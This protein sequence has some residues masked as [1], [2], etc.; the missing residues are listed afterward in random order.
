MTDPA[1]QG[2][3]AATHKL[4]I[5][6][7]EPKIG[8]TLSDYFALHGHEVRVVASGEEALAL[9]DAYQPDV[10]LLDIL[11]PGLDGITTLKH[12]KRTWPPVRVII[13]SAVDHEEVIRGALRL[14][15]D[16]YVTKPVRLAELERYV[17]GYA[18]ARR[19]PG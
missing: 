15:A 12:I 17:N 16:F 13:M 1:P 6:D 14:G 4:L 8:R 19:H 2:S 9:A 11:M 3:F 5:V 7:D 18:P 10:I